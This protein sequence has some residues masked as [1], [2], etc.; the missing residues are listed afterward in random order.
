MTKILFLGYAQCRVLDFM[1]ASN[2]EVVQTMQPIKNNVL[3][4][5]ELI[6]SFGYRHVIRPDA[7]MLAQ[8]SPV[9]LHI[10]YLP[11][12]RGADPNY[13]S[14]RDNTPKGVTLHEVDIGIDTGPII[15]QKRII[16]N[17]R[18][19]TLS[20]TYQ[21]LIREVQDLFIANWRKI[22]CGDYYA[23]PQTERGSHHVLGEM[24]MLAH[25]WDTKT[26]LIEEAHS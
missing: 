1:R 14:F 24:P 20:S 19:D 23:Y 5:F 10:S 26:S 9:N 12:N 13:W 16:F 17:D 2:N 21:R 4:R 25:G 7:L 6:I 3:G 22:A 15:A 18:E 11:W 8:R